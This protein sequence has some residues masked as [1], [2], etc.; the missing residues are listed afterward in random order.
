MNKYDAERQLFN[1]NFRL[2]FSI[3]SCTSILTPKGIPATSHP[4]LQGSRTTMDPEAN[5]T[6]AISFAVQSRNEDRNISVSTIGST[7]I[8]VI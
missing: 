6:Q 5:D 7:E 3:R 1:F 8:E 4:I 2:D